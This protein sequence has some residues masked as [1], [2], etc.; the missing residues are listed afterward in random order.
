[1]AEGFLSSDVHV[2]G[3]L[4]VPHNRALTATATLQILQNFPRLHSQILDLITD[5]YPCLNQK[6]ANEPQAV[7]EFAG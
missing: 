7:K 1:M 2:N 6:Q 5:I 4:A 3:S